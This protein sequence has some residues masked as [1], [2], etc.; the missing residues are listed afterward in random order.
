M[1]PRQPLHSAQ[2]RRGLS[3]LVLSGPCGAAAGLV[4]HPCRLVTC[5]SRI[6]HQLLKLT[7]CQILDS[8]FRSSELFSTEFLG[9]ASAGLLA[10]SSIAHSLQTGDVQLVGQPPPS[11]MNS[12]AVSDSLLASARTRVMTALR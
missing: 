5:T 10:T 11:A 2:G 9:S 1:V 3:D 8:G 7:D 6:S 4:V 12:A